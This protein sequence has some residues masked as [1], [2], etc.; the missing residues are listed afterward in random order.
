M[1]AVRPRLA[2]PSVLPA[3]LVAGGL[4]ALT[5][6]LDWEGADV[7]NYLFRIDLF[8]QVGFTVWSTAWYAGHTTLGY[9]VLLAPIG[10]VLGPAVAGGVSAVVAAVCFDRLVRDIPSVRPGRALAGSLVFAA[11]TM[12]NLAVGRLAFAI[13]LALALAALLAGRRRHHPLAGVLS[14]ATALASPVAGAF[15]ALA[16][17]AVALATGRLR[18]LLA[19]AVTAVPVLV[20]AVAFGDGGRFPFRAG[21]WVV[22]LLV[23]L[24]VRWL[25]PS[26][27]AV[28]IGAAL[29]ALAAT[30]T[31]AVPNA[32]GANVTRLGMF[33]LAPLLVA[34][35]VLWRPALITLVVALLFWQW[36]PAVDAVV[37]SGRDPSTDA[38]YYQPLLRA[39]RTMAPV[40]RLEIP[41]TLHHFEAAFVAPSVPIARGWER[42]ADIATNPIF[43]EPGPLDPA[44]YHR[45]LV[46]EGIELVALADAPLD[47]SAEAEAALL[48]TEPAFLEPVWQGA[49]WRLWRVVGS[50]GLVDGPAALVTQTAETVV[51]DARSAGPVVVRVHASALW[52]VD[53]PACIEPATTDGWVHLRAS[54]P[55]RLVLHPV[56]WGPR[57][58]CP[59]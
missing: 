56:L 7:P 8:R 11:G 34:A 43:Y 18:P 58:R 45:W 42:Q 5:A 15:L 20:V 37:R 2:L 6:L 14:L 12:V 17:V 19:A 59:E 16:W 46:D 1:H 52:S 31:F 44:T 28:R 48:R 30:V 27:R 29:Y 41:L 53:G 9:S 36:S 54:G 38:A 24:T 55:G 40:G 49:H 25:P 51:L 4:A 21:A 3:A 39:V 33:V 47:A 13:G 22:T 10:A 32:L 50:E 35:G 57:A 23:C 26:M